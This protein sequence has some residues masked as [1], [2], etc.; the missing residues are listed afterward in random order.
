[1]TSQASLPTPSPEAVSLLLRRSGNISSSSK[2]MSTDDRSLLAVELGY[3]TVGGSNYN[4]AR[5]QQQQ[6]PHSSYSSYR[7]AMTTIFV[8]LFATAF[9]MTSLFYAVVGV[10]MFQQQQQRQSSLSVDNSWNDETYYKWEKFLGMTDNENENVSTSAA[11]A[12]SLFSPNEATESDDEEE[13]TGPIHTKPFGELLYFNESRA[14]AMLNAEDDFYHYQQGWEAQITQSYCAIATLAAVLDSL[15]DESTPFRFPVDPVYSPYLWATQHT[16]IQIDAKD[17]HSCAQHALGGLANANAVVRIG[18]GLVMMPKLANCYLQGKDYDNGYVAEHYPADPSV[19]YH[20][21]KEVVI[22]ALQDPHSRIMLN[23]KRGGIGQDGGGH[24][25]PLG[26][27]NAQED[28]FLIMDVA[29]YKHPPVW[30][31][32]ENLLGGV[33]TKDTCTEMLP[34][35]DEIDWTANGGRRFPAIKTLID[36]ICIPGYRGFVVVKPL[37]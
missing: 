35:T 14:F 16:I 29:K 24:F 1:M 9:A 33:T 21:L 36:P 2:I 37:Q 26:A 3:N 10:P 5:E 4:G 19:S 13:E 27:Y 32:W 28:M 22:D 23:Y 7:K 25:S 6:Q 11:A 20:H 17:P 34:M 15:R 31:K 30:V 18:L 12:T 8:L